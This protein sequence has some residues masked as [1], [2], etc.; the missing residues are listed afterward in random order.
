MKDEAAASFAVGAFQR[1]QG[2]VACL[3]AVAEGQGSHGMMQEAQAGRRMQRMQQ[4][5]GEKNACCVFLPG[6]R[7]KRGVQRRFPVVGVKSGE[8]AQTRQRR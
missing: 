2:V 4:G 6:V 7:G 3:S 1:E 8:I 5:A